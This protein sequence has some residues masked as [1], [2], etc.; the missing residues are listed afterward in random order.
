MSLAQ[1]PF[2]RSDTN[3]GYGATEDPSEIYF[4][5]FKI[6]RFYKIQYNSIVQLI[7]NT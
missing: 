1:A 6:L 2:C 7:F 5:K 4:F 3:I